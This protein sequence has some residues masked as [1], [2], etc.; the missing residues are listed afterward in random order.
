MRPNRHPA[1]DSILLCLEFS[2]SCGAGPALI[3]INLVESGHH[4]PYVPGVGDR[5][6]PV[7]QNG[8]LVAANPSFLLDQL[9]H[10]GNPCNA[11]I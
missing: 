5:W 1:D 9:S 4:F 11:P 3:E 6:L 10:E 7:F 2:V 8:P